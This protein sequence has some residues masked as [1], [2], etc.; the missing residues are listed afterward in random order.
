MDL[1]KNLY[2]KSAGLILRC[3]VNWASS[4]RVNLYNRQIMIIQEKTKHVKHNRTPGPLPNLRGPFR[5]SG[6]PS[7]PPGPLPNLRAPVI[8]TGFT[9]SLVDT[10]YLDV[11]RVHFVLR[12]GTDISPSSERRLKISC[13]LTIQSKDS[14]NCIMCTCMENI[15]QVGY[16]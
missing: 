6:P 7:E 14:Y 8:C 4:E 13:I 1:L 9:S 5:N 2:T 3:R 16:S 11:T 15:Y 12:Y 10:G